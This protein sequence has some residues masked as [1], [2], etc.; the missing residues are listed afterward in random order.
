MS[1][2]EERE[3]PRGHDPLKL[4]RNCMAVVV[5]ASDYQ[6]EDPVGAYVAHAGKTGFDSALVGGCLALI[7]IAGD[8]RELLGVVGELRQHSDQLARIAGALEQGGLS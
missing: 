4:A 3:R 8:V 5:E 7:S 1:A 2:P 6:H